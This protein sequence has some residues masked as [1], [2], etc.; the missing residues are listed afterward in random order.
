VLHNKQEKFKLIKI[1]IMCRVGAD[2]T[3]SSYY[4]KHVSDLSHHAMEVS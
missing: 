4:E 1:K 2:V 3:P